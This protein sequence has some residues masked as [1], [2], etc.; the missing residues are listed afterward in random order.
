M[1]LPSWLRRLAARS[2]LAP[3]PKRKPPARCRLMLE[4]LE[5]RD[6]PSAGGLLDPTFGVRRH[7]QSAAR[8]PT[9]RRPP[10]PSSRTGRPSSPDR[11]P[12]SPGADSI[13]VQRLNRDGSLDTTFNKTGS[14]T[15]QTGKSDWATSITLQPDGKILIGGGAQANKRQLR[16]PGGAAEREWHPGHDV[17]QQGA[18]GL[19]RDER[20]SGGPVRPHRPGPSEHRHRDRRRRPGVRERQPVPR[21]DQADS[22]RGS[23]QDV[24]VRRVRG[25][26][27]PRGLAPQQRTHRERGCGPAQ[28]RDLSGRHGRCPLRHQHRLPGRAHLPPGPWT[29]RSA[30]ARVTCWPT[31]PGATRSISTTWWSRR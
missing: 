21:G 28:R 3:A 26:C 19:R 6:C 12:G 17:R 9:P 14:V 24:R 10:S 23:G 4:V 13:T 1:R 25:L 20:R 7:R 22:G 11:S 30:A 15:I 8:P 18:V 29:R 5:A 16:V 2:A 31:R 27:E